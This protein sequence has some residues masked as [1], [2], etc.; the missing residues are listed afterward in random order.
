[1]PTGKHHMHQG[2]LQTWLQHEN[3]DTIQAAAHGISLLML[4]Q[5]ESMPQIANLK[6]EK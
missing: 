2:Q 4:K 1:M 6:V 5:E 3:A